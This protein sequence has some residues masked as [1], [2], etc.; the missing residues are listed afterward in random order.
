MLIQE[1]FLLNMTLDSLSLEN[2]KK[3]KTGRRRMEG[4]RV[5]ISRELLLLKFRLEKKARTAWGRKRRPIVMGR[6]DGLL[7][8]PFIFKL[9][10]SYFY[11]F[12]YF[13]FYNPETTSSGPQTESRSK[14]S[15]KMTTG[16]KTIQTSSRTDRS[17]HSVLQTLGQAQGGG[18][19]GGG[20]GCEEF[21]LSIKYGRVHI[22][23]NVV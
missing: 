1:N 3:V 19:D 23:Y 10:I 22:E 20:V 2:V 11:S 14:E 12:L 7:F 15:E 4:W 8:G 16:E 21:S 17:G 13:A 9:E 5:M 6:S 18:D